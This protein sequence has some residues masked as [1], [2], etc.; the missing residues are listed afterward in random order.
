MSGQALLAEL[1]AVGVHLELCGGEVRFL[2]LGAP[3]P[4]ALRQ[5]MR[6][7]RAELA[8]ALRDAMPQQ[9]ALSVDEDWGPQLVDTIPLSEIFPPPHDVQGLPVHA[10]YCCRGTRFVR[11]AGAP[12]WGCPTCHPPG[13]AIVEEHMATEPVQRWGGAQ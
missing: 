8:A 4:P 7:H 12:D 2:V 6:A 3:L 9:G 10:C 11:V 1:E 13:A 5:R